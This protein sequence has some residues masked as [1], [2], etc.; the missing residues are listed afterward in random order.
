[1]EAVKFNTDENFSQTEAYVGKLISRERFEHIREWTNAFYDE[2]TPISSNAGSPRA[3]LARATAISTSETS[4]S[5]IPPVIF[6]CIEFNERLRCG[7]VAVDLAFLAMD[8][9]FNGRP[10]L[11]DSFIDRYVR[12]SGDDELLELLDFYKCYRAYVRG[13][14]ACFTSS[15][16]ALDD[17]A[18]RAQRN[19]ARRYFGLAYE[20]A[21][22]AERP[23]L[24]VL[25]GLMGTG[26][27]SIARF[28]R[29]SYGWHVLSTDAV[30]K[31]I[32]GWARTP[33]STCPTTRDSTRRR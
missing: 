20:Y 7:D 15:D 19:L 18:Q 32:S 6:D 14:I 22:G 28:L 13:K 11:S 2:R 8:L 9:D 21:G 27:T 16:P 33:G 17:T 30:R 10:D 23:S 1:V 5:R 31:Q 26:K 12:Q 25:Y 29:E 24:V 4:S 3:A